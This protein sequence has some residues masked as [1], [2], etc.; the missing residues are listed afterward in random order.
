[1]R[2]FKPFK[3]SCWCM[4]CYLKKMPENPGFCFKLPAIKKEMFGIVSEIEQKQTLE[5]ETQEGQPNKIWHS[6]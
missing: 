4:I 6:S 5:E 2:N 3:R 1:M